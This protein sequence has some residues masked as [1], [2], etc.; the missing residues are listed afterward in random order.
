[1]ISINATLLVQVI[2]F[3]I[4]VFI[5][6]RLMIQPVLKMIEDRKEY[7]EKTRREI[8]DLEQD[9]ERLKEEFESVQQNARMEALHKR[10]ELRSQAFNETEE[11]LKVS[12][13]KVTSIREEADRKADEQ[14]EKTQPFLR[15]EAKMLAEEI[16]QRMVGRRIAG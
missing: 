4:L 6:N 1:M 12:Q 9:A 15:D 2:H 7:L 16:I 10:N 5:L 13:E 8:T 14:I 11:F 3:L